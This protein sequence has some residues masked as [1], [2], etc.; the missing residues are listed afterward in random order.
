MDPGSAEAHYQ[1]GQLALQQQHWK[2][3][4]SEFLLSARS[5]PDRSKTHFALAQ[6]YRRLR[7]TDDADKQ[8]SLYQSLKR[9]RAQRGSEFSGRQAV[10]PLR[11]AERG[12]G[13][14]AGFWPRFRPW[15]PAISFLPPQGRRW[16]RRFSPM[17]RRKPASPGGSSTACP[18]IACSWK[19]WA[20]VL[21]FSIVTTTDGWTCFFSMAARRPWAKRPTAAQCLYRNLGNGKFVDVAAEAGEAS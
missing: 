3:A 9:T 18:P 1:L 7:R 2:D 20:A 13:R 21:A 15:E 5:A 4:E 19:P 11:H 8:F 6:L 14:A 12:L 10:S 17:S 16:L